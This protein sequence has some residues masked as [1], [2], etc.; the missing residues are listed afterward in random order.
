M[1]EKRSLDDPQHTERALKRLRLDDWLSDAASGS[2]DELPIAQSR[3]RRSSSASSSSKSSP[4]RRLDQERG[5]NEAPQTTKRDNIFDSANLQ[6]TA[7]VKASAAKADIAVLHPYF[8]D[9]FADLGVS[10]QLVASL[11]A[12]AIRRPTEVQMAC[13]PPLLAG[14]YCLYLT[15]CLSERVLGKDCIGN[16]KTGSGKTV[17]FAIPI[18]QKLSLDPYGIFSLILTPTR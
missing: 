2:E 17:A 11:N 1:P 15:L 9:S 6:S 12:M 4:P 16:A 18:L 10:R 7:I 14:T 13:I 5:G 3:S 8:A